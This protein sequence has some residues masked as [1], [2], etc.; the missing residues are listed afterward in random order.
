ML[1]IAMISGDTTFELVTLEGPDV[2][3]NLRGSFPNVPPGFPKVLPTEYIVVLQ[4]PSWNSPE[5]L[6]AI[7]ARLPKHHDEVKRITKTRFID[8]M[9]GA[10]P[11]EWEQEPSV[12]IVYRHGSSVRDVGLVD[13]ETIRS[14]P[15]T[16]CHQ[17]LE[18]CADMWMHGY[19]ADYIV[20]INDDIRGA[21]ATRRLVEMLRNPT[22][23]TTQQVEAL[24]QDVRQLR[25]RLPKNTMRQAEIRSL[26]TDL[27]SL[28]QTSLRK[29]GRNT[30]FE[31]V[32]ARIESLVPMETV[33][34][35]A[36]KNNERRDVVNAILNTNNTNNTN[37]IDPTV[38]RHL[39]RDPEDREDVVRALQAKGGLSSRH[40]ERLL[41][42]LERDIL[43]RTPT[44]APSWM[45]MMFGRRD[46]GRLSRKKTT[47]GT[48]IRKITFEPMKSWRVRRH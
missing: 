3:T 40:A 8:E 35:E 42:N 36:V 26:A 28:Y 12:V 44:R 33:V 4:D 5:K 37:K 22:A 24:V 48:K 32:V 13:E 1:L 11:T 30:V 19:T 31:A 27:W 9:V 25:S 29:H 43:G 14:M 21:S 18:L 45:E 41:D 7:A 39:L 2:D 16:M 15:L 20:R 34:K 6:E 47:K 10:F 23:E 38:L 17:I 46:A